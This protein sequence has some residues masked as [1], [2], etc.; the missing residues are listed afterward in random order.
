MSSRRSVTTTLKEPL[1]P[2]VLVTPHLLRRLPGEYLD[3]LTAAGLEVIYP[4]GDLDTVKPGQLEPCL[5]GISAILASTEVMSREILSRSQV[6]AIARMG[7][8]YDAID[9]PAAT[10]LNIAVTITPG[11]LEESVA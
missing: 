2:R 4:P 8:G 6:R 10:D 5:E 1:V 7:V 3:T 9:I 11:V